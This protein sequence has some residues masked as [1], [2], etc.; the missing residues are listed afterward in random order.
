MRIRLLA[1]LPVAL[2]MTMLC[3][4]S[5]SSLVSAVET[6]LPS[7]GPRSL[8]LRLYETTCHVLAREI[9]EIGRRATNCDRDLLCL[10]SPILCPI[11]LEKEEAS[12]YE[13]LQARF[14]EG[15][16]GKSSQ[17]AVPLDAQRR[18]MAEIAYCVSWEQLGESSERSS[19][20]E[21]A[22]FVF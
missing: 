21:P 11:L 7:F 6:A 2:L 8:D 19:R 13:R 9:R 5:A 15:C 4:L 22:T 3:L 16:A 20:S 10:D 17:D 14:E 1:F 18:F 12:R